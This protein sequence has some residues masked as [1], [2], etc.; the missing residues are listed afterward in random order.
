[1]L[2]VMARF[3]ATKSVADPM[4]VHELRPIEKKKRNAG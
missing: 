2:V 1:M 3:G 4:R